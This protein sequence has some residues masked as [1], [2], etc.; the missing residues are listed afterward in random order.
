MK[1]STI[2]KNKFP[3]VLSILILIFIWKVI[4]EVV[5]SKMILPSPEATWISFI[6]L[7][8]SKTFLKIVIATVIRGLIGFLLSCIFG[9]AVGILTGISEFLEKLMQPFL[10]M[11]KSTPV[12]SIIILALIWFETDNVP[13]FVSLLVSFP[14]ICANVSEGIKSVDKKI[15]QMA[16]IYRVKKWRILLEIYLPSIVSFFIAGIST[17]MGIG[18][19]ATVAAE[20]LSQPK[21]AIGTSLY[22][23]KIYIE[24]ENV[25]A[26]TVVAIILS[27]IFEKGL[28]IL[29][30]KM[31]RWRV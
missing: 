2:I 24:T 5:A 18:W 12:M 26:W 13:I 11:I 19:K 17:A 27:F 21:F 6:D 30:Q 31:I 8:K 15:I 23:S 3:T 9:L 25:F 20:V 16:K 22:T 29:G 10:V 28:R 4:S 1:I 14:I 7:L